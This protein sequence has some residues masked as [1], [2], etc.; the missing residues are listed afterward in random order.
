MTRLTD[1]SPF[2]VWRHL[3]LWLIQSGVGRERAAA[4]TMA[5]HH[6]SSEGRA[7]VWV[8]VGICG[9]GSRDVGEVIAARTV[10]ELASGRSWQIPLAAEL[11]LP[12]DQVRTVDG[13][14]RHFVPPCAY[15]MEAS[16]FVAA[17]RSVVPAESVHVLKL[18]S[19][20]R[21]SSCSRLTSL[22]VRDL[23]DKVLPTLLVVLRS[24]A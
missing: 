19:D 4:A 20:N 8:N 6:L 15:D 21:D 22:A 24:L 3:D 10:L 18:V 1:K 2:P 13:P 17:A 12:Y 14:E 7:P 5:L 9:H 11:A 23:V 16:G